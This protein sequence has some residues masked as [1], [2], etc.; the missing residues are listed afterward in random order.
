MKTLV[1]LFQ[2]LF[3]SSI[4]TTQFVWAQA[5]SPTCLPLDEKQSIQQTIEKANLEEHEV[6][7]R[8]VFAEGISTEA[9]TASVCQEQLEPLFE[10]IAW[11]VMN[12]VRMSSLG[13][14]VTLRVVELLH[15]RLVR[16]EGTKRGD[17]P[18]RDGQ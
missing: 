14:V 18:S 5:K 12:R 17:G 1:T 11:G 16:L 8:L 15:E 2:V 6:F 13:R 10:S 9:H 7:T 4:W 3:F